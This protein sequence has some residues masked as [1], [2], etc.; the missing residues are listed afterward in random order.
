MNLAAMF[1][2]ELVHLRGTQSPRKL[3]RKFDRKCMIFRC[4][5]VADRLRPPEITSERTGN[6]IKLYALLEIIQETPDITASWLILKQFMG[7]F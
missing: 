4:L 5:L 3:Q 7:I 6:I 2:V 1:M